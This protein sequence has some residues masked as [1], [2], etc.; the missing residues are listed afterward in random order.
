M[1]TPD[2]I[3]LVFRLTPVQNDIHQQ[4]APRWWGRSIYTMLLS[5]I[6]KLDADLA[7]NLHDEQRMKPFTVTTL[8]RLRSISPD[9]ERNL[10]WFRITGLNK[11]INELLLEAIKTVGLLGPETEIELDQRPF[12][13]TNVT[14]LPSEHLWAGFASYSDLAALHLADPAWPNRHIAFQFVSPT[15]FRSQQHETPFPTSELVFNSLLE[16]WNLYSGIIFPSEARKFSAQCLVPSFFSLKTRAAAVNGGLRIGSIGYIRF[17]SS[18]NDRYWMGILHTLAA[19]SKF[20]GVG[21]GTTMGFG[22]ARQASETPSF[23]KTR[24]EK[25]QETNS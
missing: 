22:Q 21:K 9:P 5:V 19:Y 14:Y 23:R 1:D 2:L 11:D 8:L 17:I 4:P 16:H 6:A 13:I 24:M 20:G 25:A 3:S 12:Q 7:Q 15:L 18:N 10:H